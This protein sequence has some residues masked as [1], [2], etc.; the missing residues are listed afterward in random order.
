[1]PY[2]KLNVVSHGAVAVMTLCDPPTRN[3]LGPAMCAELIGALEQLGRGTPAARALVLTGGDAAFC[4]GANLDDAAALAEGG[5]DLRRT[6]ELYYN[7]LARLLRD[8][9]MPLVT[10]VPGP[11]AG[12]GAAFALMG[13][14][15]VAA[16][17]AAFTPAFAR[18]GLVPDGGASWLLP[19]LVGKARAME[20]ALLGDPIPAKQALAWGLINRCVPADQVMPTAM[21]L[22]RRLANGPASLGLTRRL[23][24]EGLDG[25]WETQLQAEAAAQGAA[26]RTED[27]RE[28]ISAFLDKRAP[29]FRGR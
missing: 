28:G 19:R 4:S 6:V 18:V 17:T 24:L 22:A 9:P 20:M 7:P 12:V 15:V 10:A 5:A 25:D 26:G 29:V 23:I 3:A 2:T 21:E 16:D 1:M 8:L 11:A 13:D 14:L 27:F